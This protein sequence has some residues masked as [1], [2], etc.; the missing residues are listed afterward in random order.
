MFESP[1]GNVW[2]A[3]QQPMYHSDSLRTD[4]IT[5]GNMRLRLIIEEC[6][7]DVMTVRRCTQVYAT[8]P[9]LFCI[10]VLLRCS[11]AFE[12][13]A[14]RSVDTSPWRTCTVYSGHLT[15]SM[16]IWCAELHRS[17]VD[18][19]PFVTSITRVRTP[20]IPTVYGAASTINTRRS[21]EQLPSAF[22]LPSHTETPYS[23]S[24]HGRQQ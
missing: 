2:I 24:K 21:R 10:I 11:A 14:R 17:T 19:A 15:L 13:L 22:K 12:L 8:Q 20:P 18:E 4:R 23:P 3:S 16:F 7:R 9:Q 6:R 5:L 1:R